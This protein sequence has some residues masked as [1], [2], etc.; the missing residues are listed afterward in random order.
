MKLTTVKKNKTLNIWSLTL[1]LAAAVMLPHQNAVAGP[2]QNRTVNL[3]SETFM[4][5]TGAESALEFGIPDASGEIDVSMHRQG[6]NNNQQL[7]ISLAN[8]NANTMYQLVAFLGNDTNNAVSITNLTTD[9]KGSFR[10]TY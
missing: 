10:A 7:K 6:N 4:V 3:T 5:N 9:K 8:L 2:A 1:G